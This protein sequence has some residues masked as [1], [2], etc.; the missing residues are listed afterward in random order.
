MVNAGK[1]EA[2]GPRVDYKALVGVSEPQD[3]NFSE[4][5]SLD[6]ILPCVIPPVGIVEGLA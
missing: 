2:A 4:P 1:A 6:L 3:K 5:S